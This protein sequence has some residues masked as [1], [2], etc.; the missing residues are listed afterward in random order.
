[1]AAYNS[2]LHLANG[3]PPRSGLE[4][5]INKALRSREHLDTGISGVRSHIGFPG[6]EIAD[7]AA[8]WQSHLGPVAG[9][10]RTATYEGLRA[11]GKA[12]RKQLRAQPSLGMGHRPLWNRRALSAYTWMR[13]NR[14]PQLQWLHRIRKADSPLCPCDTSQSCDH[15][16]F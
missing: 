3:N 13:T 16:T 11:Y 14:G 15:I 7:R 8:D 2:A 12:I 6:N 5:R 10:P 9:A 4:R 1:M